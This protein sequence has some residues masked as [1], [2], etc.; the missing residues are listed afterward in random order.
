MGQRVGITI[1]HTRGVISLFQ[2]CCKGV[3]PLQQ[4]KIKGLKAVNQGVVILLFQ[5]SMTSTT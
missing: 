4:T 5:H 3:T 1:T 2:V